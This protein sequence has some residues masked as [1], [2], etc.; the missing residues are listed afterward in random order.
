MD[1][2]AKELE[3]AKNARIIDG[4][5]AVTPKDDCPHVTAAN[6]AEDYAIYN[7]IK[8]DSICGDC[9]NTTENWVCLKCGI[10]KCSRYVNEHMLMH[11]LE[12]CHAIALSFSDLSF[13]CYHCESYIVDWDLAEIYNIFSSKKFGKAGPNEYRTTAHASEEEKLEYFDTEEE[14]NAKIST[15]AQWIRESR[16]FIA[17]TGAG[18]STSAGIP[19]YRSGFNTVL[20]TGAGCWERKAAKNNKAPKPSVRNSI[21]KALPTPTH[22]AIVQLMQA[23]YLKYLL[24]QNVDGLHRKSGIPVDKLAELHGNAN[25]EKCK[26]CGIEYMRDYGVRNNPHVHMHETGNYCDN[27]QCRGELIDTIVNFGENLDGTVLE[28][29][30]NNSNAADLCLAM[31]SSLRV[32]PAAQFPKEVSK[33]GKLVVVNLQKTPLDK[34]ALCIHA[35]CDVVMDKLMRELQL[36]VPKF[37]LRRMIGVGKDGDRVR[38]RGLD[39]NGAPYSLLTQVVF[40]GDEEVKLTKEPFE[41]EA[42]RNFQDIVLTF[43]G[44]YGE[45]EYY[46]SISSEEISEGERVCELVFDPYTGEW[47]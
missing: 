11:A 23:G 32:N 41:V 4:M 10:V 45:P 12:S 31:G 33:H 5:Y 27:P 14:L 24:S 18:I 22:M 7:S 34:Y 42:V 43:Q 38:V 44:H 1:E 21:V 26:T 2:L 30:A 47:L 13:W 15:L 16:H 28:N 37:K 36:D 20:P 19:D 25:V 9:D 35:L 39:F 17:F 29:C 46:L 8:V 40:K 3:A 6:L